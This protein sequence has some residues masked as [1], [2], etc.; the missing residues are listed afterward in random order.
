MARIPALGWRAREVVRGFLAGVT[1]LPVAALERTA[2]Q[3]GNKRRRYRE[4]LRACRLSQI[5]GL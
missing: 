3:G 2:A 1:T 4:P 5:V